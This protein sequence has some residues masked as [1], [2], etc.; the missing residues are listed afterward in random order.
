MLDWK[1]L[2]LFFLFFISVA[3]L[4]QNHVLELDGEGNYLQLPSNVFDQLDQAT[5]EG[6]VKWEKFSRNSRFFYFGWPS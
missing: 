2:A 6:W 1:R 4:A 5:V 3:V